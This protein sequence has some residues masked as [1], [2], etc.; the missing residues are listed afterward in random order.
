M[1]VF[2]TISAL[3]FVALGWLSGVGMRALA[4][5]GRSLRYGYRT[6]RGVNDGAA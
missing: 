1:V 5:M 6:G 2:L 3:P 4:F